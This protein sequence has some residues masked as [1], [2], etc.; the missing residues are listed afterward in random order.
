LRHAT[1]APA[2]GEKRAAPTNTEESSRLTAPTLGS[3]A[4]QCERD[5]FKKARKATRED[6]A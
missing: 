1:A 3:L 5:A 6:F 4:A 2:S